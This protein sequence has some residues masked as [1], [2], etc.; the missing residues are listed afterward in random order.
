MLAGARDDQAQM[1]ALTVIPRGGT[2]RGLSA[3]RKPVVCRLVADSDL[4][5]R[6]G[7]RGRACEY[8][9]GTVYGQALVALIEAGVHSDEPGQAAAALDRRVTAP[10]PAA[11]HRH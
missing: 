7:V 9:A 4:P 3:G 8:S 6:R 1:R 10:K 2:R 11:P 5:L